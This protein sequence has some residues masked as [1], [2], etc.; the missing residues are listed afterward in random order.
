MSYDDLTVAILAG[1]NSS[2]FGFQKAL[3]T[4]K[5]TSLLSHMISIARGFSHR[6]LIVVSNHDQEQSFQKET[7]GCRIVMDPEDSTRSALNGA[8]TAFEHSESVYTLLLPVDTPLVK[9]ELMVSLLQLRHDYGAVVPS[10]PNGY[11]EPLHAVYRTEHA[12]RKGL[13]VLGSGKRKMQH[14]LDSLT[15]VLYISTEALKLFDPTLESFANAN[16]TTELKKLE[17][18]R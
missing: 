15:N 6:V 3:A 18:K 4:Y 16:T 14:F 11:I 7:R 2:R 5:G 17:D 10:W 9:K 12:Y 13:E 8:V 1:G